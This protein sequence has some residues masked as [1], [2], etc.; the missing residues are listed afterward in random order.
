MTNKVK[1]ARMG[2]RSSII[3]MFSAIIMLIISMIAIMRIVK[4]KIDITNRVND[5]LL[6]NF[7]NLKPCDVICGKP[8]RLR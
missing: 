1:H 8:L 7:M 5:V 4:T 6:V 3:A 2:K